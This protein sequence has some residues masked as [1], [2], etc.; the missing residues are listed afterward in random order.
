MQK[1]RGRVILFVLVPHREIVIE[2]VD[3]FLVFITYAPMNFTLYFM[4]APFDVCAFETLRIWKYMYYGKPSKCSI[5][6]TFEKV[7]K[8]LLIFS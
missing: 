1:S 6:I 3:V 2:T 4:I 5:F 8:T 7:F